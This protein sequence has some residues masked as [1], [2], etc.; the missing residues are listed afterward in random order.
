VSSEYGRFFF[1]WEMWGK[2]VQLLLKKFGK[3]VSEFFGYQ[4]IKKL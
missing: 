1:E 3:F 4:E 2:L